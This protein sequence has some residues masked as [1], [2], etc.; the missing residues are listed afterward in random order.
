MRLIEVDGGFLTGS[1]VQGVELTGHQDALSLA[2]GLGTYAKQYEGDLEAIV[3]AEPLI[4]KAL[5]MQGRLLQILQEN[6]VADEQEFTF[7]AQ[8]PDLEEILSDPH[9]FKLEEAV[10]RNIVSSITRHTADISRP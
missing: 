3:I 6:S 8:H 4:S 7:L 10:L 9:S 1:Y 2:N 5:N